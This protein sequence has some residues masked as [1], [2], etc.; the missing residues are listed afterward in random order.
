[1]SMPTVEV[2]GIEKSFM[3]TRALNGVTFDAGAGITGL[4]GPN[5]AG[6]TTL[7]RMMA[8]VLAPDAGDLR[9]L[10]WDPRKAEDRLAIRR[11][12]GYMPQEPGFHRNFTAFEFV[13]YIAILKEM[14]ESRTRHDEVR[15]V[16]S[17]VG[18]ESQMG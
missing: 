11:R 4:L 18:L 9:L 17:L 8:T 7:L 12:L 2:V 14:V 1:M 13:D 15:R 3:R 10:G 5:G 6:K 16:L